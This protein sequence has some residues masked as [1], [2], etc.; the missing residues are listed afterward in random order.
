MAERLVIQPLRPGAMPD[1][2]RQVAL[3]VEPPAGA[4]FHPEF[5]HL[6]RVLLFGGA[7]LRAPEAG[8]MAAAPSATVLELARHHGRFAF[9][10][11]H[12]IFELR[13]YTPKP[14]AAHDFL[15]RMLSLMPLRE[16]FSPNMGIWSTVAEGMFH[17]LH[18]WPYRD[19]AHR[20]QTRRDVGATAEWQDYGRYAFSVLAD[21]RSDLLVRDF[22]Q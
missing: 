12:L 6:N 19:L 22:P 4:V 3:E 10:P 5:G 8:A 11:G 9:D 17:V 13:T 7:D 21:M 20:D 1:Y 14:D 15:R 16:R 18:L 2:L